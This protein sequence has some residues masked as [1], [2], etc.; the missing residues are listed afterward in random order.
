M[1][2][3]YPRASVSSSRRFEVITEG[4]RSSLMLPRASAG[5][6]LDAS[7]VLSRVALLEQQLGRLREEN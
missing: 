3:S 6:I 5:S 7:L 1:Q 2:D 4:Q